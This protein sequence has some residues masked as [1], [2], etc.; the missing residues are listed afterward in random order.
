MEKIFI[1]AMSR[2]IAKE[3][4]DRN[5]QAFKCFLMSVMMIFREL[6]LIAFDVITG[7]GR[8]I[9]IL[10]AIILSGGY[11]LV[12]HPVSSLMSRGKT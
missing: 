3:T 9:S 4:Q 10:M 7:I 5:I 6:F 1:A 12:V 8:L 11:I 2:F